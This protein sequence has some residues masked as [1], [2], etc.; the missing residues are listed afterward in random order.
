MAESYPVAPKNATLRVTAYPPASRALV[1]G[2]I[3]CAVLCGTGVAVQTRINGE[4]GRRLEDGYLAA[5]ISFGSGLIL[6]CVAMLVWPA[7][8]RGLARVSVA[9]RSRAIPP[10]YVAGGAGGA[11]IVLSQGLTASVLGVALFTVA[12]VCGQTLSGLLIDGR[13]LGTMPA[14]ALTATRVGGSVL[15]LLAVVWAV[16]AQLQSDIPLWMLVLPFVAGVGIG[17]QQA[18]NGQV[19][20][21]ATSA[22]TATFIN[23]VVGTAVLV[24]ALFV[25]TTVSGW[26]TSLPTE[27]WL[28]VGGAIGIAFITVAAIAVRIT[29]VLIFGLATIAGQLLMSLVLDLV[30]PSP[31][32]QIAATTVVGTV[33][34]LVAVGIAALPGRIRRPRAASD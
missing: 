1:A 26:P 8:R 23:F 21:I 30:A 3:A 25:H 16:S 31:G 33:L 7:G 10:W 29:G 20:S 28:Y 18:V 15:A 27:P 2:T 14:K 6:L 5:T 9:L 32:H 4:L 17:W 13:G 19:R 11:V 34:T 24:V 22:L 12:T